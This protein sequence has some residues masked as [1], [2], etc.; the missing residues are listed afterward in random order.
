VGVFPKPRK[1]VSARA[2]LKIFPA[3]RL[4]ECHETFLKSS[5][6]LLFYGQPKIEDK[7][8]DC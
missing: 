7:D 1:M 5:V 2:I 6:N 8:I 3:K 4:P